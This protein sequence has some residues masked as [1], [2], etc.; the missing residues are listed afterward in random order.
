MNKKKM[1]QTSNVG[2][3]EKVN[4]EKTGWKYVYKV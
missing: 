1:I 2:K 4:G 3:E